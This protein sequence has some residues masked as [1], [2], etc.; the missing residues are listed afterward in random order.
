[1]TVSFPFSRG[2]LIPVPVRLAHGSESHRATMALDTGARRT[3]VTPAVA[4]ELGFDAEDLGST[5]RIVSAT[6]PASASLVRL[7]SVSVLG[8]R[9]TGLRVVCFPL[10]RALGIEGVLG[11]DFLNRFRVVIDGP[12]ETVT[13]SDTNE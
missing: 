5:T 1:M 13:I 8:L 6:G 9:V 12:T 11:L 4:R 2:R 10:A 7:D 3:V